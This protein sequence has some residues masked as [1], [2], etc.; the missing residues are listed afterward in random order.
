MMTRI[1][2]TPEGRLLVAIAPKLAE[3]VEAFIA[4]LADLAGCP[5]LPATPPPT[6]DTAKAPIVARRPRPLRQPKRDAT[7]RASANRRGEGGQNLLIEI[8]RA[9]GKPLGI[10]DI[11]AEAVKRGAYP[12][13]STA[14]KRMSVTICAHKDL[15]V[16]TT[17]EGVIGGR[18]C[19]SK[20]VPVVSPTRP[21]ATEPPK[22]DRIALIREANARAAAK[23]V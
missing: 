18:Y 16:R 13:L 20:A 4:A 12:D 14:R 21:V 2:S 6:A 15:V 22:V 5:T 8:L 23:E 11:A 10:S 17:V 9:A 19:L 3:A 7:V 1:G